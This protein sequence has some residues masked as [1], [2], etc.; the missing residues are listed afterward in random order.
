MRKQNSTFRTAF[1]SEAGSGLGN[2]DYFAFV[3]L[4]QYACYVV[5]DGLND[6]PDAESAGLAVQTIILAFQERPSM[7]KQAVLSYLE[8]ANKAL[9]EA[10]GRER[11]KASVTVVVTDY[12]KIRYGCAGNTRFRLYRDGL[13][14]EQTEDMSLGSD[15]VRERELPKDALSR[16]EQRNNLQMYLGQG[17]GFSPQVSKKIK[18]VNGDI[19]TLYTRGIWE[20]LDTGE[21]DDVFS[22]AKD[23]P[24]E[25]LDNVEDLLL[26]RQPK[27]LEN[28]TFAAIFVDKVFLD[29]NRKR[30]IKKIITITVMA[31]AIIAIVSL[32]AILFYRHRQKQVEELDL[33]FTDTIEYIQDNN[34]LRAKDECAAALKL[35]EKLHDKK[36]IQEI[37]D[38]QKLI[39]AVNAADDAY[40]TKKYQE[41]QT[42]YVTAKERSR[43]ADRIA[44]RYIDKQLANI[45]NYMSVFDYIQL[46]DTLAAQGDYG[47][48]EKKYLKAKSLAT[49]VYFEDGRKAAM[50]ALTAMYSD[51]DKAEEDDNQKAKEK[52]SNETGAAGLASEGDKAFA[53]GDYESAKAYYAMA[54]EKYQALGD[55]AHAQLVQTKIGSSGQKAEENRAKEKQAESYVAAGKEQEAAGN[56]L[57][58]KKQYLFAK[59]L[60]KEMKMDDKVTEVDGLIDVLETSIDQD[61]EKES[62]A[63]ESQ[64]ADEQSAEGSQAAK[65]DM[66]IEKPV[67]PVKE[68]GPGISDSQTPVA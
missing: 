64:K 16:H 33:K 32:A 12:A 43:Y 50:D 3:E 39:E 15:M 48:A 47:R 31:L 40:N 17:T 13:V 25:S 2:N 19:L 53:E 30:K 4:E 10:E 60:Y 38:Y 44:D 57:E 36:E 11:L 18:L 63:A 52:A 58:A 59:N 37:S 23:E 61:K 28:Y 21:L 41:A 22:E 35:A 46:G 26:S 7:K 51:R 20:N 24:M 34:Y 42:D 14:R 45:T 54:L 1:L 5:A 65:A 49:Q 8:T 67:G 29:P 56:K 9:N 68:I 6:L 62:K 66:G 27:D 55:T